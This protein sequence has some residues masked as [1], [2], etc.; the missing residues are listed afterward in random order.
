MLPKEAIEHVYHRGRSSGRLVM[1]G[2]LLA[3]DAAFPRA[4]VRAGPILNSPSADELRANR[5][6]APHRL[7]PIPQASNPESYYTSIAA[8]AASMAQLDRLILLGHGR[9]VS[10]LTARGTSP[11][12][13]GIIFGSSDI[14]ASNAHQLRAT[15][16]HLSRTARAEL[17]VCQAAAAGEAGGQSGT[18]LCQA[19][20][21]ALGVEV[22]APTQLQEYSSHD[23]QERPGGGWQSTTR[24]LPWEGETLRFTPRRR[25]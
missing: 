6:P 7:L 23:Q 16:R 1:P 13:T 11:V 4:A 21:D 18:I 14:T 25:R 5:Y 9:V 3:Y 15:A 8:A 10:A 12:T 20:A 2:T 19:I 22:I 24:F 17:W